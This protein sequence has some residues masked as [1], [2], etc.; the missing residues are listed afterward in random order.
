MTRRYGVYTLKGTAAPVGADGAG[1][2]PAQ[3][4]RG[5][6]KGDR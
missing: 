2:G 4:A 5:M 3:R 1:A 6:G